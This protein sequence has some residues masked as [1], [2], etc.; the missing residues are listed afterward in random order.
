M[1]GSSGQYK[2]A[3]LKTI[4]DGVNQIQNMLNTLKALAN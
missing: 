4:D 1:E 2:E 3:V